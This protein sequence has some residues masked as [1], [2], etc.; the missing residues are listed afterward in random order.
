MKR[1]IILF[2]LVFV[3]GCT[4]KDELAQPG[5][6]SLAW[7]VGTWISQ[8][9]NGQ[10]LE[11][12]QSAGILMTGQGKMIR[13]TDT[14]AMERLTIAS[15]TNG[16]AYIVDFPDREIRFLS[17][18]M[19]ATSAYKNLHHTESTIVTFVNDTNDFPREITYRKQNADSL[20]IT[21]VGSEAG[22]PMEMVF[23]MKKIK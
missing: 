17:R 20:Y 15:D 14:S 8:D 16:I 12:W 18:G 21:L 7:L 6:K 1:L 11:Q 4:A 22:K 19:T 5:V 3:V 10:F 9:E 23:K 2:A 13:G